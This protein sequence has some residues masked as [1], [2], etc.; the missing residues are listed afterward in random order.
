M[1]GNDSLKQVLRR[2]KMDGSED[3]PML[4]PSTERE[5]SQDGGD[6][7]FLTRE[8]VDRWAKDRVAN[9]LPDDAKNPCSNRWKNMIDDMMSRMWGIF[10][11][12]GIFLALCRHGFVL[13]VADMV[14]SGELSKYPLAIVHELLEA[15]GLKIG[16]GYD[17]GCHFETTLRNSDLGDKAHANRFRSLVGSFHG[18]AHNRLCQLSFLATYVKG[19][20][21]E[22]LKGC[23]RYFSRSN[24]LAKSVRYASKFHRQQDITT[25]MKQIDDLETYANLS[26]FLCDNYQQ[27]LKILKSEPELKRWMAQ[28][29]VENYDSFHVWLE[30]ERNYLLGLENGLPMKREGTVEMEYV[31]KLMSLEASQYVSTSMLS[32]SLLTL[33]RSKLKSI[34]RAEQ[35]ALAD[36]AA[37][38]PAPIS[39]VA[40]RHAIEQ[41]NRDMEQ[42]Q[43][44]ETKLNVSQQW[45]SDS[46]EWASMVKVIKDFRY[47][48]ALDQIEKII[49]E[50]L[51]EMTKIHQSG[52]GY[53]M[54]KHIAKALQAWS[55]AIKHAIDRYNSVALDMD[56][57]MPTLSWDEVVNYGFLADFDILRDTRDSICSRPW[58]RP[59]YWV[60]MDNYF[61]IL[62]AREEIKRLNIEIK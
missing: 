59:S 13:V 33:F 12:T 14:R 47:Q 4:G 42:V 45:T 6:D 25:F 58:T 21:L 17:I 53:K 18:H 26:K 11:E 52:T 50:R 1:D 30:E 60:A 27:A 55:K 43:D 36:G 41:W 24:G 8:Q 56:P 61:K 38:N 34:L 40:R 7:Y 2:S 19:L 9:I 32:K 20:G 57:P 10:D 46:P 23:K 62:R 5:D 48:E 28:E 31:K 54:Q 16:G 22:D 35:A 37:F 44:L 3:E 15:F 29:G 39:Q 51:F 49:V